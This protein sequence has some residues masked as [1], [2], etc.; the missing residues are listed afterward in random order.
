MPRGGAG[1]TA[2]ACLTSVVLTRHGGLRPA[3]LSAQ[4]QP[5]GGELK[6]LMHLFLQS[7]IEYFFHKDFNR[8]VSGYYHAPSTCKYCISSIV[9][10]FSIEARNN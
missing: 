8:N 3:E 6:L 4:P 9:I 7:K 10:L 1:R 5:A 2:A